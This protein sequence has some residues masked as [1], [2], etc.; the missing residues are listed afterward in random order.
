M[1]VRYYTMEPPASLK[2]YIRFFWVLESDKPCYTHRSVAD[3]SPEMVF[4][5]KGAFDELLEDGREERSF[6]AGIHGQTTRIH[7]FHINEA[8]GIFGIYLFP[9]ALQ[10]LFDIPSIELTGSFVELNHLSG[11]AGTVLTEQ[12]MLAKDNK[13]RYD[14][15]CAFFHR[16]LRQPSVPESVI[17]SSVQFII[18]TG[19]RERVKDVAEKFCLSERQFERRFS[20][21][22][23]LPPKTF[24]S[25]VK[26]SRAYSEY[27]NRSEKT[28][29]QVALDCGYYDQSHFIRDFKKF[30]GLNPKVFFS[31]K[32]DGIDWMNA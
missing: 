31:G 13:R 15:A 23:G 25:V 2:D 5:Y 18:K 28:L 3:V 6:T 8:F 22:A 30:S 20:Q 16:R 26:F 21:Y 9:N 11:A 1:S 4:H 19:G 12:M 14:L 29:T 27:N 7:R 32:A 10:V 24:S 17:A